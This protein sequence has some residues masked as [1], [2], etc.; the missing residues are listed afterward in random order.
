LNKTI[1]P[2]P[3]KAADA[4]KGQYLNACEAGFEYLAESPSGN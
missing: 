1:K 4:N 2:S 3:P